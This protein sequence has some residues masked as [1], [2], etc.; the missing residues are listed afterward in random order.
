MPPER[1]GERRGARPFAAAG[2]PYACSCCPIQ[3]S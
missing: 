2:H 3:R 1:F